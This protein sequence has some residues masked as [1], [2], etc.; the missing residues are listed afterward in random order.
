MGLETIT[1][2]LEITVNHVARAEKVKAFGD[3]RQLTAGINVGPN[4]T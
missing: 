1:H 3:I 4:T 2:S